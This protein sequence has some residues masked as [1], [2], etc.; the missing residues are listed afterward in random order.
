VPPKA[1]LLENPR[2]FASRVVCGFAA[3]LLFVTLALTMD[4]AQAIS[5]DGPRTDKQDVS[6][7]A[8]IH[9][10]AQRAPGALMPPYRGANSL[11]ISASRRGKEQ[12]PVAADLLLLPGFRT[13]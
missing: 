3:L 7:A 4:V 12:S 13:G 1:T 6:K 8:G 2:D 10:D 9:G 5:Q 11:S